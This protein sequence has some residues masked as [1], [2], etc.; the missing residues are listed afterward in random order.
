MEYFIQL[1]PGNSLVQQAEADMQSYATTF[2]LSMSQMGMG[3]M[4]G[5]SSASNDLTVADATQLAQWAAQNGLGGIFMWD[6]NDDYSGED[7]G[8]GHDTYANAIQAVLS[9]SGTDAIF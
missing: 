1:A 3:L 6:L 2:G 8:G 7:G 4:P 9:Q 5:T